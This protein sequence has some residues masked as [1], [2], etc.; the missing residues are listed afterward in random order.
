MGS[1]NLQIEHHLFP[2]YFHIHYPA[3][4]VILKKTAL[5]FNLPYLESP[6]FGAALRS[7][8]RML[9]KFGKQAYLEREQKAVMAA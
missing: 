9:K 2:K 5:E 8:Y 4:S 3:I 1:L 6:S 7:D